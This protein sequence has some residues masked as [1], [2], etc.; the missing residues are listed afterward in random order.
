MPETLS[1]TTG[2][3]LDQKPGRVRSRRAS[4]EFL[5]SGLTARQPSPLHTVPK[6]GE[7]TVLSRDGFT[8]GGRTAVASIRDEI[9]NEIVK[10]L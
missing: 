9:V 4:D 10:N 1:E 6:M 8:I 2:L 5:V 7:A 3:A